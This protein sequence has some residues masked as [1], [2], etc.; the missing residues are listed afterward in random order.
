MSGDTCRDCGRLLDAFGQCM[1]CDTYGTP[2]EQRERV[3]QART[4]P[5]FAARLRLNNPRL[6][7][8]GLDG[9]TGG[10]S[11]WADEPDNIPED[12]G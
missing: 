9:C 8:C 5:D 6:P 4:G 10:A 7:C 12:W 1:H 2:A 11:C 3:L